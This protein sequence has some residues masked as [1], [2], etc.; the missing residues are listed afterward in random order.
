MS[1]VVDLACE[2]IR[3]PSVTPDDGEIQ[4]FLADLFAKAGFTVERLDCGD[5]K[6]L[7]VT[8]G[9][10]APLV[11]FDGHCD[12]VPPGPLDAW[13]TD[14]FEPT[15]IG[16]KI[17]GRGAADM[18]G[19]LAALCLAILEFVQSNPSHK[20]TVGLLVTSD[21]EGYALDGTR[22]AL[23]TLVKRGTK[24]D[25]ALVGEP[26]SDDNFGDMIKVGRRGSISAKMTVHGKQGHVAYPHLADNPV[27]RL[28]PFLTE[29]LTIRWDAGDRNFPPT[30]LQVSN[31]HAG[32]GAVNVVPGEA[33]IDF[34]LRF[35]ILQTSDQIQA[36]IEKMAEAFALKCEFDWNASAQPFVTRNTELITAVANAINLETKKSPRQGTGGGTSDARF[37]ALHQIPVVE[38]GPINATIHAA[39]ECVGIDELES[40]VRVYKNVLVTLTS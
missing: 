14:P 16:G 30:T 18:K 29:L 35:N 28:A 39:N 1:T 34:N 8:H 23:D 32:T 38:F 6:N 24:I 9:S 31:I 13:I 10:G 26:T 4:S 25:F 3:R 12:V 21:E 2:L 20:G 22:H 15:V 36:R 7:W 33:V 40:C 27:H 37:F 19:P 11:V 17:C 5:V